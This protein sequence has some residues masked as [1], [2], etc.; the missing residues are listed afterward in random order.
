VFV[1]FMP[2]MPISEAEATGMPFIFSFMF[3]NM[4]AI[5]VG[6]TLLWAFVFICS[7][8]LLRRQEWARKAFIALLVLSAL[9]TAT[10]GIVQQ[11][12]LTIMLDAGT[13][14]NADAINMV[15]MLRVMSVFLALV[16]GGVALWLAAR[17]NATYVREEFQR[18]A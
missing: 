11:F 13:P 5:I 15:L 12:M 16:F 9:T 10:L 17:L 6:F 3:D 7:L 8:G 4:L 2:E 1:A 14:Q 18:P